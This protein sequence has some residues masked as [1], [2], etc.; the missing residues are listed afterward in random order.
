MSIW[1]NASG[2]LR[3]ELLYGTIVVTV[4]TEGELASDDVVALSLDFAADCFVAR[5]PSSPGDSA[6]PRRDTLTRPASQPLPIC[7][8]T[9][10]ADGSAEIA[11]TSF[12]YFLC[13]YLSDVGLRLNASPLPVSPFCSA[14]A[15]AKY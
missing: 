8:L 1:G 2:A 13:E 12:V 4:A 15:I 7:R 3:P 11:L 10:S 14:A 9:S 6:S 5:T